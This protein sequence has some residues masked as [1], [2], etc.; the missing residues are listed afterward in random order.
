MWQALAYKLSFFAAASPAGCDPNKYNPSN[1]FFGFPHWWQYIRQGE[2]DS[3]TG[4]C[5]PV[6]VM[7]DGIWSI[8]LAIIDML[9]YLGGIVAVVSII[10]AGVMYITSGGN[11][12]R[13]ASA[14]HRIIN[15]LIGLAFVIFA[16]ALVAFI[17]SWLT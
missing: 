15:S 8:G 2:K 4:H 12:E 17:G 5:N 6:V 14:L 13:A 1:P 16:S 7:P 3:A 10:Y 11:S 9:L